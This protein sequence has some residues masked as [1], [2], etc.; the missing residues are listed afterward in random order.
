MYALRQASTDKEVRD[1]WYGICNSTA[2]IAGA[3]IEAVGARAAAIIGLRILGMAAGGW[4]TV[5]MLGVQVVIWWISPNAIEDWIDHSAFGKKRSTGG[6]KT[7]K[8]QDEKMK[9][10]L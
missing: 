10:A 2:R 4:I 3:A 7:A 9:K 8:E 6:Y 5:G 1:A